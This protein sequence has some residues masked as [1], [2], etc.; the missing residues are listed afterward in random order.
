MEVQVEATD[1]TYVVLVCDGRQVL[2]RAMDGGETESAR[3]DSLIRLSATDAGAVRV[4]VNGSPC[5]PLGD[6]GTRAFGYTIRVD[7]YTRICRSEGGG[8]DGRP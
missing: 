6:P 2:N 8:D 5:L 7:D 3:C 4:S 1:R